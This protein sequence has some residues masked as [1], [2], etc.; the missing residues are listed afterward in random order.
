M[1]IQDI[2]GQLSASSDPISMAMN[3]LPNQDLKGIFSKLAGSKTDMEK[4]QII[5]DVCN[6]NGI[7]KAQFESALR[8][9]RF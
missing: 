4:A 6:R 2:I 9:K 3:L 1:N 5:A 8:Q 7:T